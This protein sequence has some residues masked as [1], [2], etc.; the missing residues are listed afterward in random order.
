M[1][2]FKHCVMCFH[3]DSLINVGYCRLIPK[4][5]ARLSFSHSLS[6][7]HVLSWLTLSPLGTVVL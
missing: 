2:T 4:I 6:F 7:Y 3:R 1:L 5:T